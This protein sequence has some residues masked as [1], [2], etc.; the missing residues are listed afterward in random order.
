MRVYFC[1]MSW[2]DF[3]SLVSN[4]T[5]VSVGGSCFDTCGPTDGHDEASKSGVFRNYANAPTAVLKFTRVNKQQQ[6]C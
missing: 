6:R 1:P 5:E 2:T 3:K 4:F